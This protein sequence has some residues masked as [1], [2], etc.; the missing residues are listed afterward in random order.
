M[1]LKIDLEK[2]FHMLEWSFIRKTLHNLNVSK[3]SINVIMLYI[4]SNSTFIIV[5]RGRTHFFH[6]FRG[7]KQGDQIL[8]SNQDEHPWP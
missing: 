1:I 6:P 3:S 4:F 7:I 8:V 2:A 5:I